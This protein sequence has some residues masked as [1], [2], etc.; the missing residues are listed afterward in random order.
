[1]YKHIIN[2]SSYIGRESIQY[3]IKHTA[4]SCCI[5]FQIFLINFSTW[6]HCQRL[7]DKCWYIKAKTNNQCGTFCWLLEHWLLVDISMSL[8]QQ[9]QVLKFTKIILK[10]LKDDATTYVFWT[11]NIALDTL[12]LYIHYELLVLYMTS[13][14]IDGIWQKAIYWHS[15]IIH[16]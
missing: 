3:C 12:S 1:M 10:Y 7:I 14:V 15:F 11:G 2:E 8:W 16:E 13:D 5:I 6:L 4:L 9:S